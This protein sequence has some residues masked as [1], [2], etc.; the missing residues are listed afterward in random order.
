MIPSFLRPQSDLS[1]QDAQKGLQNMTWQG[2]MAFAADGMASGGFL[3]AFALILGASNFHIGIM[4]A[5]PFIVQPLQI[6]AVVL[7]ERMRMRKV[8][9][10]TSY[11]IAYATWIP[12]AFIPF[13]INVPNAGAVTLLLFFIAVRG[14]ATAFVTTSWNGWLRD[15]VPADVMG[16]FFAKRL[17]LATIAAAISALLAALFIDWW[18]GFAGEANEIFGYS[19]AI[20]FGS[21]IL[22]FGAV[23]FMARMPEPQM[24]RLDD[25]RRS[26]V[27]T[28]GAPFRD[29]NFRGLI[30]FMFMWNFVAQMAV[31]FFAVYMLLRLEM[32]LSLVVGLGVL[33]QAANVLFIRVW[34]TYVDR[35]GSKV[36]L[37]LCSSLYFLVILAWTFT[38]LPDRHDLTV[39]LL[40]ILHIL[41]GVATAGINI[42]STTIRMKMSP[43]AESTAYLTAV[44]L[45]SSVAAGI[46][47]LIGGAFVDYF[48][49]RHLQIA[50]EWVSPATEVEFPALFLTG[51]D[52]LFAIAFV[53]GLFTL[54]L[55]GR[56][57]EEGEV[58]EDVVMDELMTQTRT[59]LRS[60]N[61]VPGLSVL[62]H[63]P[64]STLRYVPG[65]PGLDVAVGVTVYQIASST[66]IAVEGVMRGGAMARQIRTRVNR[67]V[68]DLAHQ[69]DDLG[70]Q[71]V[72]VALG[73]TL[74]AIHAAHDTEIE[75]ERL[76]EESIR[77]TISALSM[78][79]AVPRDILRG[80]IFGVIRG[81]SE[82]NLE[83]GSVAVKAIE[84]SRNAASTLG[85]SKQE[86]A[87]Y[88]TQVAVE[89]A[90][91]LGGQV[92]TEIKNAILGEFIGSPESESKDSDAKA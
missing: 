39:P 44:S 20:L 31:P 77:G 3:A 38:T 5:I 21:I 51:Y 15:I 68:A 61:S 47:P 84:A 50:V 63:F 40:V 90:E 42:A 56:I 19:Y 78:T 32:P 52:F 30:S 41:I 26:I 86:V 27:G 43:P 70:K 2:V 22:G 89:A 53:L 67:A 87:R 66:R 74:G 72:D 8:V 60:L 33:S 57:K 17:R 36:V 18:K 88:A 54:T 9:A 65:I 71:G 64:V 48:S 28:L 82:T 92:E 79:S 4:T 6:L 11:L 81:A 12:V 16:D 7:V 37:S 58:D 10:V 75:A 69:V 14:A 49:V 62:S 83:I 23:Q 1:E 80:A 34:G 25:T 55:L 24:P 13:I 29:R 85:L 59:N 35:F 46:S 76:T 73:A 45:T 91:D